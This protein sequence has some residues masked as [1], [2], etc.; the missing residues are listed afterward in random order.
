MRLLS[1]NK[2]VLILF[3]VALASRAFL[4]LTALGI[5]DDGCAYGWLAKEVA[6]GN[7]REVFNSILPPLFPIFTAGASYIFWDFELSGRIVSCLF[8]SLTVFPLFFL[9][10][11]IFDRKIAL[12]TVLFFIVHPYLSQASGE[13][14]TEA[15]YFFFITS[16]ASLS[17]MA[18]QKRRNTLFLVVG[19][20]LSLTFLTRFEGFFLIFLILAWIWLI[21]LPKIRTGIRWK[22]ISSLF[23]LIAF[24]ISLSP[25]ILFV[26]KEAGK[27]QISSR[28]EHYEE[29][30]FKPTSVGQTPLQKAGAV[31]KHKITYGVPRIPFFLAKAYHPVFLLLLFFGI[32]RRKRFKG[33]E[34]GEAYILSFILLRV[35]VLVVSSGINERYLYAFIPMALCWAGIGFWEID[36]RLKE[37]FKNKFL[38]IGEAKISHFSI[39]ILVVI[40]AICL[41]RGLRPIRGHRAIQREVGYWLKENVGQEEFI[42]VAPSPQESFHAGAKWYE[43]EGKTYAEVINNARGKGA[44]FMIVNR[45][46]DKICPDFRDLVKADDLEIFTKKFEKNHKKIVI[47]KLKK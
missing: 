19:L 35:A 17:W 10:K 24:F 37:K 40:I 13:V 31:L 22:F 6:A 36:Y 4:V 32:I 9:V 20:L 46:I 34:I 45:D 33:F 5:A 7:F 28:Q 27:L 3:L 26:S 25:Y 11:N 38:T 41:P 23:C 44:D 39:I 15:L 2:E 42:I 21:N 1:K 47:Y 8:G 14:L 12:M 18:I 43:L 16:V 29:V 30:F